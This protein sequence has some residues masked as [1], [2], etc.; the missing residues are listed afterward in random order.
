MFFRLFCAAR[1]LIFFC[2]ST[3]HGME[4]Q[5]ILYIGD[6]FGLNTLTN[7]HFLLNSM[8]FNKICEK[9]CDI[10]KAIEL[11]EANVSNDT[12]VVLIHALHYEITSALQKSEGLKSQGLIMKEVCDKLKKFDEYLKST[13]KTLTFFWTLD[14]RSVEVNPLNLNQLFYQA[15]YM[16]EDQKVKFGIW[17]LNSTKNYRS[18]MSQIK[19]KIGAAPTTSSQGIFNMIVYL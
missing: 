3:G 19:Q 6:E 8:R 17:R 1:S 2:F 11:L 16:G 4:E 10:V 18:L 9:N 12:K 5:D 15:K 7:R 14:T 13:Y